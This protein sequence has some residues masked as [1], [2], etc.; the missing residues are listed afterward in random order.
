MLTSLTWRVAT[1]STPLWVR[2]LQGKYCAPRAVLPHT[3]SL[4][5]NRLAPPYGKSWQRLP[6]Y[7]NRGTAWNVASGIYIILW[8]DKW[9][10]PNLSLRQLIQA[11][12]LGMNHP[13]LLVTYW[14]HLPTIW[15]SS[16]LICLSTLFCSF[17]IL[18]FYLIL[19]TPI[20]PIGL[21]Q[22]MKFS[23]L[24][25]PTNFTSFTNVTT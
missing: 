3:N 19:L 6:L 23:P 4:T 12:Y 24:Y 16:P 13:Y 7:V 9:I 18:M 25:I 1:H 2:V 21:I 10:L 20:C 22:L 8:Y 11:H 15:S 14:C 5:S 17:T